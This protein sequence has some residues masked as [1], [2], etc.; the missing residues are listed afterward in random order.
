LVEQAKVTLAAHLLDMP[1]ASDYKAFE[2]WEDGLNAV[3]AV[4]HPSTQ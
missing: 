3:L 4:L 2:E 1:A